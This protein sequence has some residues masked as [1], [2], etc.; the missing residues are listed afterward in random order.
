MA[1]QGEMRLVIWDVQHGACAMVQHILGQY[2][3]RLAALA[4]AARKEG[5]EF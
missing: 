2:A 5:L 4:D 3:G 1:L